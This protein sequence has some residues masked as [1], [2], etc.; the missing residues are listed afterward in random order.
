MKS[1]DSRFKA[2]RFQQVAFASVLIGIIASC[3]PPPPVELQGLPDWR[4]SLG[5]AATTGSGRASGDITLRKNSEVRNG[6][7]DLK[8]DRSGLV[9][10]DF[11]GPLGISIASLHADSLVG[12]IAIQD[13]VFSF[14]LNQTMNGFPPGLGNGLTFVEF[15]DLVLGKIPVMATE[16]LCKT[17]ADSVVRKRN[18]I[19]ALWKTDTVEMRL[20]INNKTRKIVSAG[21]NFYKQAPFWQLRMGSF[22]K[23]IAHKIRFRVNDENYFSIN[24][25]KVTFNE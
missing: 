17:Q 10:A 15:L 20:E 8:I 6:S 19:Y 24:Y 1:P 25:K 11:Y 9:Q 14:G 13:T 16:N 23:G 22:H 18:T 3:S 12:K 5:L 21:F 7:F 4:C 2:L